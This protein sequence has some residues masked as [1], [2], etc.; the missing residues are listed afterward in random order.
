MIK[1]PRDELDMPLD[2]LQRVVIEIDQEMER[3][4]VPVSLR[5]VK[6]RSRLAAKTGK[7]SLYVSAT[8]RAA[9]KILASLYPRR[10]LAIEETYSGV[11]LFQST[12]YAL[13][14]G[15]VF[16]Q[17][18]INLDI[19]LPDMPAARRRQ[20][21]SSPEA[22][23]LFLDQCCDVADL[24]TLGIDLSQNRDSSGIS[25]GETWSRAFTSSDR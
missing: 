7:R 15:R 5:S 6:L 13:G 2:E 17:V 21:R 1:P 18:R 23:S 9:D 4:G 22:F 20:M 11:L 24:M 8:E 12:I 16:G 25:E 3:D 14:I 19:M 10:E